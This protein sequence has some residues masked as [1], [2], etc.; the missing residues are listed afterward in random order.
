M[1]NNYNNYALSS[2]IMFR[3]R[4]LGD[5]DYAIR[6]I[7][8][9]GI[10]IGYGVEMTQ[11]GPL[12]FGGYKLDSNNVEMN[13]SFL[14]DEKLIV[15]QTLFNKIMSYTNTNEPPEDEANIFIYDN[16]HNVLFSIKLRAAKLVSMSDL[17]YEV[18]TSSNNPLS[19]DVKLV[20]DKLYI[21]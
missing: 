7:G 8:L 9:P 1:V 12:T 18:G 14:V 2:N 5:T 15:W 13:L 16:S 20:F 17:Q 19:I 3:S 6:K 21:N 10:S 11:T 4:L